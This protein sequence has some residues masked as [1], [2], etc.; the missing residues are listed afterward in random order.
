MKKLLLIG[1]IVCAAITNTF[2][3][4]TPDITLPAPNYADSTFGA[5]P[6]TVTNF[7]G[8]S[9]GVAYTQDLQFKVPLDAA[10]VNALL[11]GSVIQ[12]FTV[13]AVNGLPA[14]L[15][16]ACNIASC[17]FAG[18]SVGCAQ[19]TG[20]CS[21]ADTYPITIDVTGIIQ[22]LPPLPNTA[23]APYQ[24]VGYKIIVGTAGIVEAIIN[25]ITVHPNPANDHIT[26]EG[27][28]EQMKIS[29]LVI[30]NME[31]KVIKN[32]EVTSTTMDVNLN[33]FD[34]GVYFVV[35][36]HAGGTETM[37]FIKE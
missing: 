32:I 14:G 31:G 7:T 37:K 8:A 22:V 34:N 33:G 20:V 29:S 25:P 27:L 6:D 9:V 4:C 16:Y 28:N 12:S 3:Q 36:N 5:W 1:T 2:A 30:T 19:I 18:G 26:I 11:V 13:D 17:T 23:N 35:A 24:F 10:V 15:S 21:L